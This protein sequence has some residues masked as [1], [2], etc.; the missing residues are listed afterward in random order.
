MKHDYNP[1]TAKNTVTVP[2]IVNTFETPDSATIAQQ[3]EFSVIV[4]GIV[5]NPMELVADAYE[6][7][8]NE[9]FD[10]GSEE[11]TEVPKQEGE[12]ETDQV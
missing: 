10:D 8:F 12:Q 2:E 11:E 7:I 9:P 4:E 3:K 6:R 1:V 5:S